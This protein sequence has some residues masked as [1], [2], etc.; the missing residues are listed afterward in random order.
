MPIPSDLIHGDA[1]LVE[2]RP[3]APRVIDFLPYVFPPD[4]FVPFDVVN[5]QSIV[6]ATTVIVPIFGPVNMY[7]VIRWFGNEC[8][9]PADIA[10][11]NWTILVGG[12]PYQPYVAMLYTRG[13]VDNP[14]PIIIRVQPNQI[15]TVAV[16][17]TDGANAHT[18]ITRLKGW[19]Y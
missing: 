2:S 14:D 6:A 10:N 18:A 19:F 5:A 3:V 16:A 1:R 7:A 13:F 4:T 15:V 12:I 9:V 11:L 8:A 17:N